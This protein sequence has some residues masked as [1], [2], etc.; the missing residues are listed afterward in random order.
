MSAPALAANAASSIASA[1]ELAPVPATTG[2]RPAAYSTAD[3]MSRQCSSTSTVGDSPVV[4]TMTIPAVPLA[5]WKSM[6]LRRAGRSSAPPSRIGVAIATRLPVSM[7]TCEPKACILPQW[8]RPGAGGADRGDPLH[9][10]GPGFTRDFPLFEGDYRHRVRRQRGHRQELVA[11][12]QEVGIDGA[13]ERFVAHGE[14]LVEQDAV[15]GQRT[16]Q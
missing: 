7:G 16:P 4:P 10:R 15:R 13:P 5:T 6:S 3:L 8:G 11:A 1:V 2:T 12:Q 14:C 9:D